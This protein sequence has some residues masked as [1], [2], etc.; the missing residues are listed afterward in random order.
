MTLGPTGSL[1]Q[2]QP[3]SSNRHP[4]TAKPEATG[5]NERKQSFT[6]CDAGLMQSARKQST[7]AQRQL[8]N[9]SSSS[10]VVVVVVVV[11]VLVLVLVLVVVVVVVVGSR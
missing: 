2:E 9:S 3:P 11:V 4:L 8:Q 5:L 6:E 1:F 7:L 10:S